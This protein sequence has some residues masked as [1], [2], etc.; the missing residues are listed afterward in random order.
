MNMK[1]L[2]WSFAFA[3]AT[4]FFVQLAIR[5]FVPD[6]TG[7]ESD[8]S[9]QEFITHHDPRAVA[10]IDWKIDFQDEAT[11]P[12]PI[13]TNVETDY[14]RFVFSSA[15]ASLESAT[16]KRA[17]GAPLP[18]LNAQGLNDRAFVVALNGKTPYKYALA[19]SY[20]DANAI[21][22]EYTSVVPGGALNKTFIINKRTPKVELVIK[23]V[24]TTPE[25]G[26]NKL[27]VFYPAPL[28]ADQEK[29]TV[30]VNRNEQ[31]KSYKNIDEIL[32]IS[33]RR[34][35]FF[36]LTTQFFALALVADPDA[37]VYRSAC[38]DADGLR[39]QLEGNEVATGG[40]WHL[41][42]Y[43]GPK[44]PTLLNA[45]DARL[46][47]VM[48][49]GMLSPLWRP[50]LW[51]INFLFTYVHDY[52]LA[53]I[54]LILLIKLLLLPFALKGQRAMQESAELTRKFQYLNDKYRDDPETLAREREALFKKHG[55]MGSL[56][57]G[58]LPLLLQIPVLLALRYIINSIELF[59]VPFLWLPDMS[60][61]DPYYILPIVTTLAMI[62]SMDIAKK[63]AIRKQF[64][65]IA[66]AL[67]MGAFTMG[68]PAGMA[69][70]IF[71]SMAF[72]T[73]R[74]KVFKIV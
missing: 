18:F 53:L 27:R 4:T 38:N 17:A 21:T 69:L 48:E 58:F 43:V 39:A 66:F 20:D 50:M 13:K 7:K 29:P 55:G 56:R 25:Q 74:S 9:G 24:Q 10:P 19:S 12:A 5:Y 65:S 72:D 30:F 23:L 41:T 68:L 64:S 59:K 71:M 57:G 32:A 52:G 61:A 22:L 44:E 28:V 62:L 49:Y 35:T 34:P 15:G 3:L 37:F 63:G 60:V 45:V 31:I 47:S 16:L 54:L 1:R 40:T 26:T 14:A 42:F 33:W 11:A 70:F 46:S 51:T 73:V 6:K 2:L 67:V 8:A 36:A